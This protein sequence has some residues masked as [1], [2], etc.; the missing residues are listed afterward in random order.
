MK[1]AGLWEDHGLVFTTETGSPINPS[2]LRQRSFAPLLKKAGL[3]HVRFHDLRHTCATLL[4][5]QNTHPQ[6]RPRASGTRHHNDYA[7]YLLTRGTKYGRSHRTRYR[8]RSRRRPAREE[9]CGRRF[10]GVTSGCCTKAPERIW[11]LTTHAVFF[12]QNSGFLRWAMLDSNQRPPPCKGDTITPWL[13]A[14]VQ[15]LLQI[16][17]FSLARY[18]GCSLLF[19]WVGVKLVSTGVDPA[20][21]PTY[22]VIALCFPGVREK[23]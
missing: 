12:L 10:R 23:Q 7:G 21:T 6:V 20:R 8:R 17:K 9:R 15:K 3:P 5:S 13:F 19:T 2:N 22:P 1:F 16:S 14:N 4:L 18:H 11:G